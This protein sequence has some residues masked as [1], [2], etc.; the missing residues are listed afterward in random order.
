MRKLHPKICLHLTVSKSVLKR[1]LDPDERSI[2]EAAA[3]LR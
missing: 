3:A 1:E 2:K